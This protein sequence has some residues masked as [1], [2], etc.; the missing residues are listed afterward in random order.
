MLDTT[1]EQYDHICQQIR[2]SSNLIE[3]LIAKRNQ[4]AKS[5]TTPVDPAQ[6]DNLIEKE[7]QSLFKK[8]D[9]ANNYFFSRIWNVNALNVEVN[10]VIVVDPESDTEDEAFYLDPS[11]VI[12]LTISGIDFED[13]AWHL[14]H[15]AN[16]HGF[17]YHV[18]TRE[19]LFPDLG[20][21]A[22]THPSADN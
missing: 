14:A 9:N 7:E 18:T 20:P 1:H 16:K 5:S 6:L 17:H 19:I 13:E 3:E 10:R 4:K 11:D 8:R 21:D 2:S 15:W 22:V 12:S